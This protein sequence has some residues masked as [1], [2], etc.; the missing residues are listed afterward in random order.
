M[1]KII[2]TSDK[3]L[4]RRQEGWRNSQAAA[5][6]GSSPNTCSNVSDIEIDRISDQIGESDGVNCCKVNKNKP[7]QLAD[8]R[9]FEIDQYIKG[10][11]KQNGSIISKD[12]N[13][14]DAKTSGPK[15]LL[16]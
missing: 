12:N 9:Q 8:P 6:G 7:T 13:I 14:S 16:G 2:Q 3:S 15:I 1:I 11:V 4:P 5:I 10:F